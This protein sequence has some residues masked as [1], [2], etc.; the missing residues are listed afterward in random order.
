MLLRPRG[1]PN[2]DWDEKII[3]DDTVKTLSVDLEVGETETAMWLSKNQ[4]D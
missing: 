2:Q 4:H 1:C 3:H